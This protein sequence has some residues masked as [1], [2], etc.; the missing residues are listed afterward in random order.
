M[1]VVCQAR[2]IRV[3]YAQDSHHCVSAS[4]SDFQGE[5]QVT[6]EQNSLRN[7]DEEEDEEMHPKGYRLKPENKHTYLLNKQ[8]CYFVRPHLIFI[9]NIYYY[10]LETVTTAH[11]FASLPTQP[12]IFRK[13]NGA[14]Q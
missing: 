8:F 7:E 2:E 3:H 1:K 4:M 11:P 9:L 10:L 6:V 14:L 12:I 5:E 13:I